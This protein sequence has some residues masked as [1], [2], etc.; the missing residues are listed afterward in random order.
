MITDPNLTL[1]HIIN[2]IAGK[3]FAFDTTMIFAAQYLIC[4]FAAYL[5]YTWLAKNEY[6]QEALFAGYAALLGLGINF[7]IT[8]FYF[9]PRPFMIP[10]G[11]LLIAHVAESSFPSDHATIMFSVSL[12][13][14]TS[15]DLRCNGTILFILA[16]L[17]GLARVYAGLHFPMDMAGSLLVASFSVGILLVLKKYLIPVNRILITYFENIEKKLTKGNLKT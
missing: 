17:S 15:R 16:F 9:H 4:I 5:A 13:L 12:M 3:N 1:F 11:T 6:R 14:L 2:D 8:L 7:I 10:T